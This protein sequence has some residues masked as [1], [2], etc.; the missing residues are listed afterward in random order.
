MTRAR[1][2]AS[3]VLLAVAC[4]DLDKVDVTRTGTATVPGS[5]LGAPGSVS[6][7]AAFDIGIGR[8]ALREQGID[9]DDVD[10]ARLIALRLEVTEGESLEAW[11]DEIAFFVEAPGLPRI[12]VAER[13]GIRSL[14]AETT[15]LDLE[16]TRADLKPYVLAPSASVVAEGRGIPPAQDTTL[17][18]TATIRVDVNV[19]GL[20]R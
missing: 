19:S 11:L 8:D 18:A 2:L 4:G 5:P 7:I 20:F 12:L 14:P 1:A 9:A 6:G 10:S 13:Q 15:S 16:V 17:R 3:A